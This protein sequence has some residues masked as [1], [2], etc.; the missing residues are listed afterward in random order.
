[1]S[2]LYKGFNFVPT[3]TGIPII[4]II[5]GVERAIHD[6]PTEEKRKRKRAKPPKHITMGDERRALRQLR[7]LDDVVFVSV[8]KR[9]ATVVLNTETYEQ[10]L[11]QE[12]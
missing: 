2:V 9:N 11:L 12:P 3:Q 10:K 6:L 5:C 8:D 7:G 1:M 4:G